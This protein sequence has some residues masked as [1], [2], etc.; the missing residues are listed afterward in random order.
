MRCSARLRIQRGM[1]N[2]N[3]GI[4]ED[5]THLVF[6]I[7]V[8]AGDIIF[9]SGDIFGDGVNDTARHHLRTS[10]RAGGPVHLARGE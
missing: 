7:G 6:R 8:N 5:L 1:L 10:L 4:S 3:A 2:R 9:D